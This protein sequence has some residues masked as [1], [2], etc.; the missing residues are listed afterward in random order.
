MNPLIDQVAEKIR[1]ARHIVLATHLR[2]D[3]DAVGSL[4]GLAAILEG[5]GKQVVRY[6]EE[7]VPGLYDFL[8][9][10]DLV[11]TDLEKV[12]SYAASCADDCLCVALD[13]GDFSRLGSSGPAL[14]MIHPF[15][16]IDHHQGNPGFGD[17]DWIEAGRSST[18]EMVCDLAEVLQAKISPQAAECLYTAITTDTGSFQYDCTTEHTFEVAGKL[19]T[20]GV[21]PATISQALHDSSSFARLA[22]MQLVL[23]TLESYFD[24]QIGVI[25]VSQK[26][27]QATGTTLE[28][29][30]GLINLP[31]S[32]K[33]VRV[34]LFLKETDSDGSKVSVSLR[35]KGDCDV[36]EI[37]AQ[38]GGGGHRNA[39][40]CR[41]SGQSMTQVRD[42]MLPVLEKALVH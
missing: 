40:G 20:C 39:A 14:K 42:T 11:E 41:M 29:C 13:C 9:F 7:P 24:D 37:A 6:L 25:Q 8:P 33:E 18:G 26:M 22:L 30:E 4:L 36:A 35:A 17:L 5:M 34:A 38:F 3:G 32:V 16:V 1:G 2:P 28:D 27:L 23:A 21:R 19:V 31:R 15:V 10:R 12:T